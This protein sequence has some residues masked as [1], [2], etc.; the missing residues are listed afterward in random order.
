MSSFVLPDTSRPTAVIGSGTLGQRI[1]LMLASEGGE[2]R[3]Y[4]P[5]A[6]QA[7]AGRMY[8]ER[9]LGNVVGARQARRLAVSRSRPRSKT[10]WPTSGWPSRRCP[11][12]ST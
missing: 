11:S 2:V 9:E 12:A 1:A 10:R 7:E 8:V 5:N 4:D 6:E 3:L